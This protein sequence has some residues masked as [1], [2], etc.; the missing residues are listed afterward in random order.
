MFQTHGR[1]PHIDITVYPMVCH[2]E[3]VLGLCR[4]VSCGVN[5][6]L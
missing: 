4:Q 5:C 2:N 3:Q 1:M 6:W